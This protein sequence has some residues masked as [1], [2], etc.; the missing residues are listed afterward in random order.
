MKVVI[1]KSDKADFPEFQLFDVDV[2][3]DS[4]AYTSAIHCKDV[5]VEKE[6]G[7]QILYF[8][9]LDESHP[10]YDHHE[11]STRNFKL[12][13]IKNSF[14]NS[15]KRYIITTEI[16]L[17]GKLYPIELS[18]SE[19]GEMRF[20]VLLGRKLLNNNFLIDTSLTNLSFKH[21]QSLTKKKKVKS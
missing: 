14:G 12:K 21:K 11:Y 17:F 15:E 7:K 10:A 2:K 3:V 4:G 9:L 8:T 19:R 20:P 6:K 13:K 16:Q 1:G 18:L 5:R